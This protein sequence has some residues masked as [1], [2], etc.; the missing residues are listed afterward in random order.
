MPH[1][2][3]TKRGRGGTIFNILT[4]GS[5]FIEICGKMFL[6][7]RTDF[8]FFQ[9]WNLLCFGVPDKQILL[10]FGVPDNQ[11][12]LHFGVPNNQILIHLD[13]PDNCFGLLLRGEAK[14][15]PGKRFYSSNWG[16]LGL[17]PQNEE[18]YLLYIVHC[19]VY[20]VHWILYIVHCTLSA[21]KAYNRDHP[22]HRVHCTL[23]TV[24]STLY[25]VHCTMY[26]VHCALYSVHCTGT[27]GTLLG[28]P[29]RSKIWLSGTPK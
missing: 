13:V 1:T 23:Y 19:T 3:A 17:P 8:N 6:R 22:C 18:H 14:H 12:L 9:I 24:Q 11:I 15:Q 10:H 27:P 20:S 7:N 5:T 4:I 21:I 26:T 28:T 16:T 29:K 25:T 2:E